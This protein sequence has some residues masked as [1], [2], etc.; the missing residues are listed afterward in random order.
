MPLNEA[1]QEVTDWIDSGAIAA[2]LLNELGDQ[3]IEPTADNAQRVWLDVL[4][5]LHHFIPSSIVGLVTR[6]ELQEVS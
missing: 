4:E 5:E 3:D 2:C 1:L 6:G